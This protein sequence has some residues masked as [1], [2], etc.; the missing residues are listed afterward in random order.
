MNSSSFP[1]PP[2]LTP[3]YKL[4]RYELLCP[5]AQGGMASVWLARLQGK[6]GFEKLVAIK[7]ILPHFAAD[8][9]FRRM[10]LD[11]ARIA[12]RIEHVNVAQILDLGEQYDL[13]YLVMEWVEGDALSKLCRAV[14][15]NG[16]RLPLGI[17]LRIVADACS[18]LHAAH[19]LCDAEGHPLGVVHRDVSPQNILINAK[20]IVKIIDFGVARAR[21]RRAEE[22][23][24]GILKGKIHYMAPEQATGKP[25]D[26]RADVWAVGAI[27]YRILSGHAPFEA[28]NQLATLHLLSSGQPPPA[29]PAHVPEKISAI[30]RRA[31]T[32]DV[33]ERFATA[34]ELQAALEAAMRATGNMAEASNVA[35]YMGE[36]LADR[37]IA[38]KETLAMAMKSAEERSRIA[39]VF[40]TNT[41]VASVVGRQDV[42]PGDDTMTVAPNPSPMAA[43]EVGTPSSSRSRV[44][45]ESSVGTLATASSDVIDFSRPSRNRTRRLVLSFALV[46]VA[47]G[48]LFLLARPSPI[49]PPLGAPASARNGPADPSPSSASSAAPVTVVDEPPRQP[50]ASAPSS[51]SSKG[52]LATKASAT[53]KSVQRKPPAM[54]LPPPAPA[55]K[56]RVVDD[57]F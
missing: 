36:Q 16:K 27:L 12:S 10:F 38:R 46:S 30:V 51:S 25:F 57:G 2:A 22:T 32:H 55:G 29:L 11:E 8:V 26:R 43:E 45:D 9:R 1:V 44:G 47:S 21:D 53:P 23:T 18:G 34:A 19:E 40:Q 35:A 14:E 52:P 20:G 37:A 13:L 5:L 33:E 24:T 42:P 15:K 31:L 49:G 50:S 17:L 48:A 3:G 54:A 56:K 41:E 4:D 28:E 39:K 6:H 7:T